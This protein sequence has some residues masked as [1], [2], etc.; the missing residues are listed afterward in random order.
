MKVYRSFLALLAVFLSACGGGG[1][2]SSLPIQVAFA[3]PVPTTIQVGNTVSLSATV[4]NDGSNSG[5]SWS[6]TCTGSD[7]GSFNP[8][9]T[10]SDAQTTYTPPASVPGGGTVSIKATSVADGSKSASGTVTITSGSTAVLADGTYVFHLAG[11]DQSQGPY[12]IAGAFKVANGLIIGGEEDF[13]D[14]T[15]GDHFTLDPTSSSLS[16]SGSDLQVTLQAL[17]DNTPG[18]P[19]I[20]VNGLLTVRGTLV[21]ATRALISEHDEWATATGSLDLQTSA[22]APSG[23]YAFA[24]QGS[25]TNNGDALAAGGILHLEGGSLVTTDSVLDTNDGGSALTGQ[26]FTSGTVSTADAYGRVTIALVPTAI[27]SMKFSVYSVNTARIYLIEDQADVANANLGG[28]GLGQGANAGKFTIANV[29][30]VSYAFGVAGLDSAGPAGSPVTIAG[31][32]GLN[33]DGSVSGAAAFADYNVHQGNQLSGSWTVAPNGRVTINPVS[34]PTTGVTLSFQMYLDGNGNGLVIGVDSF[35]TTEGPAFAQTANAQAL[36]GAYGMTVLGLNA[37]SGT[38]SAVGPVIVT[39]G[40]F[41]GTVDLNNSGSPSSGIAVSGSQNA[42][43]GTLSLTGLN[44]N[45]QSASTGWGYYPIDNAR[46]LAIEV[47]GNQLGLLWLE[48]AAPTH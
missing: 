43:N 17:S 25:D 2:G 5:V 45:E 18:A 29:A 39:T 22:A 42:G 40:A 48:A 32:F 36:S 13:T 31:G 46:T 7:C 23:T 4:A 3:P 21:S 19:V 8:T 6:V 16:T 11:V 34:F 30:G 24:A 38:F 14:L 41:S 20:G 27:A 47:D 26:T 1:G 37:S 10:A 15:S 28:V 12:S 44:P 35:Q 33:A 9:Q